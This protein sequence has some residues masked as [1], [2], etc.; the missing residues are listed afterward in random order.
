MLC[1]LKRIAPVFLA[2]ILLFTFAVTAVSAAGEKAPLDKIPTLPKSIISEP[3]FS[4][5]VD[6]EKEKSE[7][8]SLISSSPMVNQSETE[9]N[10]EKTSTK[11]T[12]QGESVYVTKESPKVNQSV[13]PESEEQITTQDAGILTTYQIG[14]SLAVDKADLY[15]P[16]YFTNGKEVS[17]SLSWTPTSSSIRIGLQDS[18]GIIHY[19]T[20]SGGSGTVNFTVNEADNYHIVIWNIGPNAINYNGY[21][22][23]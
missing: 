7:R 16:W 20:R 8:V 10:E 2:T 15:G 14:G 19:V 6:L 23:I 18:S 9:N 13:K 17:V 4:S 3:T 11:V 5:M 21:I 1:Y 22:T 12:A